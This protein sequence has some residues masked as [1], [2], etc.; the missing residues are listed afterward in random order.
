MG[1]RAV[2]LGGSISGLFAARALADYYSEVLVID[3]DEMVG[4]TG[5]R[6]STPQTFHAQALLARGQQALEELFPG[7]TKELS[8]TGV[9]TG[10]IGADLRWYFDGHQLKQKHTDLICLAAPRVILERHVRGRVE[11]IPNVKFMEWYDILGVTAT[12]E[13]DRITGVRILRQ[14]AAEEE[15]IQA[16]L[17][18]DTTGRGSR[19]PVWLTELGYPEVPTDRVKIGLGYSTRHYRLPLG[20]LGHDLAI[21]LAPTP[22]YHRGA[23]FA[24]E[25]PL[26]DGGERYLLT[27]NGVLGD[28]PPTDHDGFLAFAKSLP[29]P[30]IYDAIV[31]AEPLDDAVQFRFPASRWRRFELMPRLPEGFLVM[32]DAV[33]SPNPVYAQPITITAI[34]TI[35]LMRHLRRSTPPHPVD[36][37]KDVGRVIDGAWE[38]T[39]ASDL[40]YPE[41]EGERTTRL[42][43][44]NAFVT[45]LRNAA[46][47]DGDL[48][49]A[50]LRVAGL[51]DP[52]DALMR[53]GIFFKV[54]RNVHR[55]PPAAAP[56]ATEKEVTKV[57]AG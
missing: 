51:V 20:H 2:V 3:R 21:V 11:A 43:M 25:G 54:M 23:I 29:V 26:E 37:F 27:L 44:A 55:R 31:N 1:N 53:P 8:D 4:V 22:D 56:S 13:K 28:H 57:A 16:D 18:I 40:A 34:A 47:H 7:I 50:F 38:I 17:I 33:H 6:R 35:I 15:A 24:R 45:Q 5:S 36:W 32:G 12:P 48:A 46:L 49:E 39:T 52:A 19:A 10:D 14:G 41:T 42:R 30:D 9:P